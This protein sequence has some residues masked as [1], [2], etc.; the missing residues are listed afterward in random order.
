MNPPGTFVNGDRLREYSTRNQL[1]LSGR[2]IPE[3]DRRR[4]IKDMFSRRTLALGGRSLTPLVS[5]PSQSPTNTT[6]SSSVTQPQL[7][8]AEAATDWVVGSSAQRLPKRNASP[9]AANVDAAQSRPVKRPKSTATACREPSTKGQQ[10]L[11]GYFKPK[12]DQT[13]TTGGS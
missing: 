12:Q 4:S 7:E 11:K 1:P 2:L 5:Q 8:K 9:P 13:G 10:S 3:F 6:I